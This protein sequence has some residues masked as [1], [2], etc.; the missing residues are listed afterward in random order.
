MKCLVTG[1]AGFIGSH[2]CEELIRQGH[3]VYGFDNLSNGRKENIDHL[4]RSGNFAFF[5]ADFNRPTGLI[6]YMKGVDWVFHLGALADVVPSIEGPVDYFKVNVSGSMRIMET[7]RKCGVKKVVY[8]ASSSCYGIPQ[9]YPTSEAGE[10]DCRYPYALTKY[11]GEQICLHWGKVYDVPTISLRLFNVYGPRARTNGSYGAVFGVFLSQLSNGKPFTIIGDGTQTRDFT[12]V[13]DVVD[14]FIRAAKSDHKDKIINIGTGNPQSIGKL[15]ELLG[16]NEVEYLPWRPGEPVATHANWQR[17][18]DLLDWEP[19]VIFEEGVAK[20]KE[21]V[22]SYRNA[23]LWD[24]DTIK[25]QQ[26]NWNRYVK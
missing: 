19:K 18:K 17:A 21:L 6:P 12:Y 24:A 8:A 3:Q 25:K 14:A 4:F 5:K 16:P 23:P 7:A 2:L 13:T 15:A 11:L 26:E 20:M 1:A 10:I 22:N 9:S